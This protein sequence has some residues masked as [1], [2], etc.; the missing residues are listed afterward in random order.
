MENVVGEF[1]ERFV[2]H[3]QAMKVGDP[4]DESTDIG[5]LARPEAREEAQRQVED[6]RAKGGEVI[7]G[8]LPPSGGA[9]RPALRPERDPEDM[10]VAREETF[11]PVA[12]IFAVRDEE[13]MIDMANSTEFG[14][15][16]TIWSGDIPE[17][18][19]RQENRLGIC[20]HQ[21]TRVK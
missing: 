9:F 8:P 5:P 13:E 11:G 21:S 2:H 18:S 20:R 19:G 7:F 15:G 16:A 17:P 14:L 6:A 3:L 1:S 10:A 4:M 12:P